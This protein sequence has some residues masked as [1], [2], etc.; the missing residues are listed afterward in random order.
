MPL[1]LVDCHRLRRMDWNEIASPVTFDDCDRRQ[2]HKHR[3]AVQKHYTCLHR[4]T[5]RIEPLISAYQLCGWTLQA[6]RGGDKLSVVIIP[7]CCQCVCAKRLLRNELFER[8]L[9]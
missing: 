5:T 3:Q 9:K 2:R 7:M 1:K 8:N 6:T 4:N